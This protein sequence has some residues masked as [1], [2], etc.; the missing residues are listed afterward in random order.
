MDQ[1]NQTQVPAT[2]TASGLQAPVSAATADG[3]PKIPL[4][5]MPLTMAAVRLK[6]PITRTSDGGVDVEVKSRM[7]SEE[8]RVA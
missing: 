8:V 3:R 5:M 1:P 2:R 4:P 7:T 6:R